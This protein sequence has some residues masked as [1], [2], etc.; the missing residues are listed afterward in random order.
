[1][2]FV[3]AAS[4]QRDAQV[5]MQLHYTQCCLKGCVKKLLLFLLEVINRLC[6][7]EGVMRRVEGVR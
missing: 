6:I 1:M 4:E 2:L 5:Q 3:L 7:N